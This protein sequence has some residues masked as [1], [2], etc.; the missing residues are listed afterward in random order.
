M[1]DRLLSGVVDSQLSPVQQQCLTA[2]GCASLALAAHVAVTVAVKSRLRVLGRCSTARECPP[3]V[4]AGHSAC[5]LC[6]WR[7]PVPLVDLLLRDHLGISHLLADRRIP[8]IQRYR[9]TM[10]KSDEE[11]LPGRNAVVWA[12]TAISGLAAMT[13]NPLLALL[14]P[15]AVPALQA[16]FSLDEKAWRERSLRGA[17]TLQVAADDLGLSFDEL[18]NKIEGRSDRAELLARVLEASAK[19]LSLSQKIDA[20]GHVLATALS[21]DAKIDEAAM[22]ASVLME[23]EASHARV[24]ASV[25]SYGSDGVGR[26]ELLNEFSGLAIALSNILNVL[27]RHGL[28]IERLYI[29]RRVSRQDAFEQVSEGPDARIITPKLMTTYDDQEARRRSTTTGQE[30]LRIWIATVLGRRCLELLQFSPAEQRS[31]KYREPHSGW[32]LVITAPGQDVEQ[33]PEII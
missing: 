8:D 27:T 28:I 10:R 13:G 23:V 17:R 21:D 24:L 3:P 14:G 22:L 20:L 1:P 32:N 33:Y 5:D 15:M 4:A 18:S 31:P 7:R 16:A 11:S 26:D 19:T 9:I 25:A 2:C 12:A 6:D 30:T 29:R